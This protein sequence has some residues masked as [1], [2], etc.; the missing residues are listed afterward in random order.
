[1]LLLYG[2]SVHVGNMLGL[3]GR[4]WSETPPLWRLMDVVLLLFNLIAAPGLW[5]RKPWAVCFLA[6]GFILLQIVP[7]TFF[8]P[9]FVEGPDDAQMLS[10]LVATEVLLLA[11]LLAL[12]LAKR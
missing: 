3:S 2:A 1:M 7:Y 11:G 4:P 10:G 6:A 8:R 12:I 5:L 9:L